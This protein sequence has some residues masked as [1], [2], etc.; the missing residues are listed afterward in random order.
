MAEATVFARDQ[1]D[2]GRDREVGSG[3]AHFVKKLNDIFCCLRILYRD[4]FVKSVLRVY[5]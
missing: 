3:R 5:E 2:V 4:E 1:A